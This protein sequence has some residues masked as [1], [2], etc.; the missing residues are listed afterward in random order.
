MVGIVHRRAAQPG[1][2]D[3][4]FTTPVE[5]LVEALTN[6]KEERRFRNLSS[7]CVGL[8]RFELAAP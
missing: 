8:A 4:I 6:A 7:R 5:D 3:S 1:G 2:L